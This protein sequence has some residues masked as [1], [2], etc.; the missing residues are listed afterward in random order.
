MT[1]CEVNIYAQ[2]LS[3]IVGGKKSRKLY[4]AYQGSNYVDDNR[5]E[6][7]R[8]HKNYLKIIQ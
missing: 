1:A 4:Q 5:Q 7:L 6:V 3:E 2:Q 8:E